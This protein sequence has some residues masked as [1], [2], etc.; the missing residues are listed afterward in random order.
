MFEILRYVLVVS[1]LFLVWTFIIYWLH[2]LSHIHH[3]LN[4]LWRI[5]SAHHRGQYFPS[6]PD[7]KFHWSQLFFWH[8][9]IASTLDIYLVFTAPALLIFLVSPYY[10]WPILGFHYV[11]EAFLSGAALDHNL[12]LKGWLTRYFAW[13][14]Y[15]LY[16][17]V[18][19][20]QN[21]GLLITLWDFVFRTAHIPSDNF[22]ES[23]IDRRRKQGKVP[24][25]FSLDNWPKGKI[26][27]SSQ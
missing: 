19:L 11:Y 18:H 12:K 23:R 14:G 3:K 2:R 20:R 22:V 6:P 7:M 25:E 5:H 16:H 9:N 24:R 10:G 4:L 1:L 17:H 8:G 26:F 21:Y 13:G 15:H 27:G